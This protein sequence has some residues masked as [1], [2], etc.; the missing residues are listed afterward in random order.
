MIINRPLISVVIPAY[1]EEKYLPSC[2]GAIKKQTFKDFELIVVD[3]NSKDKTAKVARKYG[4]RV[5][6]ET[7]QGMIPARERG[8]KEAEAEIIARTDADTV[9]APDWLE[10]IYE[11]FQKKTEVVAMTGPW[12]SP[13]RKLPDKIT[14]SYSY[15][16]S[17][18][19]G[20]MMSGH[21]YLLG[22]NYALR[23]SVWKKVKVIKD[24]RKVHEDIDLSC[25]LA[26]EGEILYNHKMKVI[27]SYR[28]VTENPFKGLANYMGEYPIRYIKTLYHNK[29][30]VFRR[31]NRRRK[32]ISS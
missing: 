11:T 23:K 32:T 30:G 17:V 26:N 29:D 21:V 25:H 20:K 16:I 12:L 5:V 31:I 8:F 15:F 9:V 10:V 24:D 27:C 19:L 14:Q 28:R 22:P 2:L 13:N 18:R 3:N 6:K 1:N 4:A 7:K